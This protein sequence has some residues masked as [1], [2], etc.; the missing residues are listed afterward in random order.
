MF[1]INTHI[2]YDICIFIKGIKK[3]IHYHNHRI[4][5]VGHSQRVL[6]FWEIHIH[7]S[8]W[9]LSMVILG[10]ESPSNPI[11]QSR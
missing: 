7:P 1:V 11:N 9:F 8:C 4:E 6:V 2:I 5:G 3:P 10:G